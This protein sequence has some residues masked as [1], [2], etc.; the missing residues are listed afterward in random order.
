MDAL[1]NRLTEIQAL[2]DEP[3]SHLRQNL[4]DERDDL[5]GQLCEAYLTST[6]AQRTAVRDFFGGKT[7]LLKALDDRVTKAAFMLKSEQDTTPLRLALA[8]ASI[9]DTRLDYRELALSLTSLWNAAIAAG[10]DPA[11]HFRDIAEMSSKKRSG[12]FP[13]SMRQFLLQWTQ[14]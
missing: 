9:N 4:L 1:L 7:P 5:L 12:T 3:A 14:Q 13:R 8:A 11:R 10:L 6:S 2:L